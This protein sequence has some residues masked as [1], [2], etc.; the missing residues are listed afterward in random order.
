MLTENVNTALD[1]IHSGAVLDNTLA[2]QK[3]LDEM[4]NIEE[5]FPPFAEQMQGFTEYIQDLEAHLRSCPAQEGMHEL[6]QI[7]SRLWELSSLK[8]R[9]KRNMDQI[10]DLEKEIEAN[11]SFLDQGRLKLKQIE[12]KRQ[13]TESVLEDLV[14]QINSARQNACGPLKEAMEQSLRQLG[15]PEQ[16]ALHFDF[17]PEEIY[18]GILEQRPRIMWVPNP[19]QSPQPLDKIAS[20]GELSRFLLALVGLRSE[21]NLPTLLFDEV[22]AGIGGETLTKVGK[23]IRNLAAS[24]QV[25]LITHWPQLAGLADSHFQVRKNIADNE[26]TTT[27]RHLDSRESREELA[28]MAGGG[29]NG[30]SM[31]ENLFAG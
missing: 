15:F 23:H 5:A 3:K 18:P 4:A 28:R 1:L 8:R 24:R 6:E 25:I 16:I 27:C 9:L 21:Q 7:E 19:G 26:T 30:R 17:V 20:G 10:I 2:L 29:T 12:R 11:L 14:R 31:A 13:E 22:D